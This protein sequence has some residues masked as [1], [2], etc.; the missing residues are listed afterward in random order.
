[1]NEIAAE[2]LIKRATVVADDD[3]AMT[4]GD[5]DEEVA[6]LQAYLAEL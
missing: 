5:G 4:G 6:E 2:S 1:M 3:E